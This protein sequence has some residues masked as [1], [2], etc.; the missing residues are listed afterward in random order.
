VHVKR[1][2]NLDSM[3]NRAVS[4]DNFFDDQNSFINEKFQSDSKMEDAIMSEPI[5]QMLEETPN[6]IIYNSN[7]QTKI[8]YIW[9]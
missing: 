7:I 6:L 3:H 9:K 5:S 8:K 4:P 1:F 2:K